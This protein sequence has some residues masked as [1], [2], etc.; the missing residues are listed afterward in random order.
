MESAGDISAESLVQI[1]APYFS[2]DSPEGSDVG[3]NLSGLTNTIKSVAFA[4]KN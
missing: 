1:P 2:D 4:S 3:S